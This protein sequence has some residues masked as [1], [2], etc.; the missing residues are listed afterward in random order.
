MAQQL[1][2]LRLMGKALPFEVSNRP[3]LEA[4]SLGFSGNL[5]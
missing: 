3:L 2:L 1:G 5:V 4:N